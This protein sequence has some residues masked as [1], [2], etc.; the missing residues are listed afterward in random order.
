VKTFNRT[1]L[2][3]IKAA[4]LLFAGAVG[5]KCII[6]PEYTK[7]G[8]LIAGL[9]LP[10]FPEFIHLVFKAK[11]SFRIELI[12]YIFV[13]IALD[14]GICMDLYKT[15]P[16]FD[17]IV[18]LLSGVLSALVGHYMLVYFKAN[19]THKVFKAFFIM[20][21]SIS[22]GVL[23]EFFE[24]ACDKFLGQSMQQLVSVGVDA[25]MYDLLMATIGSG[26]GGILLTVP[27]FV[28][29]LESTSV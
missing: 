10:F 22:I 1:I 11:M 20:F 4:L 21:C 25:T 27:N 29:Y 15:M 2:L 8:G 19:K 28:E 17:K 14:M 16:Y 18:H 5:V 12:Y 3:I 26:I 9:I 7:Y 23:W 6:D 13:F 24:F